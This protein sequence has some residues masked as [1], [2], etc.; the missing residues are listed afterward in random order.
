MVY[1]KKILFLCN[2][3]CQ[4]PTVIDTSNNILDKHSHAEAA[5]LVF[6]NNWKIYRDESQ[7]T[8]I[9]AQQFLVNWLERKHSIQ[10][11]HRILYNYTLRIVI[12]IDKALPWQV[13]MDP[14]NKGVD[15]DSLM[16][17]TIGG[18]TEQELKKQESDYIYRYRYN[19][20]GATQVWLSS[21]R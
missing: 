10:F 18:L 8:L 2:Y 9:R 13:R 21:G 1:Y 17:S 7:K 15:L 19:G 3:I 16:Y 14:R 5:F 6:C 20:G 12:N 4:Q 11:H